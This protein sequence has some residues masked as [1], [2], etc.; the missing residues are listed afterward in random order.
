MEVGEI[1]YAKSGDRHVAYQVLGDGP[2][3]LLAFN[4]GCTI[5]I[6]RDD[7]PHWTRF[8]RRLA[9]FSRLIRFDPGG[10][11][12]SDPLGSDSGPTTEL[13]VQD[14]MAGLV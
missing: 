7:E 10:L 13:R 6:D 4:N 9:S 11:G 5:W 3:D 12:L 8:D 1:Q 14:A 2:V